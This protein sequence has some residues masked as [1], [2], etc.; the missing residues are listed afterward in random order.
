MYS[1]RRIH[2]SDHRLEGEALQFQ[3]AQQL[4]IRGYD[5]S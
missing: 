4:R 3:L 2:D 5:D 1:T